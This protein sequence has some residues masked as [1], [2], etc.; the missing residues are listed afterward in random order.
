MSKVKKILV[1][2]GTGFIGAEIVK[3]LS[4]D[5]NNKITA[6]DNQSRGKL[7]S[8]LNKI[9][10][11]NHIKYI[12]LDLTNFSNYENLDNDFDEI[13]LLAGIVGVKYTIETPEKVCMTNG[14][15]ILNTLKWLSQCKKSKLLYTSTSETYAGSLTAMN[16]FPIPTPESVPLCI[17]DILNTRFSYAA[18][19]IYAEACVNAYARKYNISS[20]IIRYHNVYGPRM[21]YEHVIP[22]LSLRLLRK[23]EPF[24]LYGSDQTR[25]FCYISDAVKA[26]ISAMEKASTEPKIYH[27][28]NDE[29]E[30]LIKDLLDKIIN[31][32]NFKPKE[33]IYEEAPQGS[34]A[35]RCPDIGFSKNDF[36]FSP[37]ISLMKG[38]ELTFE[39][40]QSMHPEGNI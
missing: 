18:S 32:S 30:I 29:E 4:T 23:E 37:N 26:T 9:F 34:P 11:S 38:L 19:K 8:N 3:N 27:I 36:G 28:G 25:A 13:F 21:G 12:N 17:T 15:I 7:D 22:E 35:R 31:L 20:V 1:L 14:M 24:L 39:W 10:K 6:V 33:I 16:N 2:G 5:E 40:Y